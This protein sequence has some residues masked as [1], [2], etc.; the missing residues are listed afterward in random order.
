MFANLYIIHAFSRSIK[1][2]I[3]GTWDSFTAK[4]DFPFVQLRLLQSQNESNPQKLL[5]HVSRIY[6]L[7]E[8]S[9]KLNEII[10]KGNLLRKRI[11]IG[12]HA[13]KPGD[14]YDPNHRKH[15]FET[16]RKIR[17]RYNQNKNKPCKSKLFTNYTNTTIILEELCQ[18]KTK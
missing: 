18:K 5:I 15:I 16:I 9:P 8:T 10:K 4:V 2:D 6:L 13:H 1:T 12:N 7:N 14:I 17:N 3:P 11:I